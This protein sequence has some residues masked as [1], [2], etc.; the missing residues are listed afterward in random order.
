MSHPYQ[1]RHRVAE[2]YLSGCE[3]VVDVGTYKVPLRL[4][5]SKLV[6]IDPLGVTAGAEVT[7]VATWWVSNRPMSGFGLCMLGFALEGSS[8]Q[9]Q[10]V[11]EM[12]EAAS[13]VVV[14]WAADYV[15]Q[16]G[17][18]ATLTVGKQPVFQG[19]FT[20]PETPTAGFPVFARRHMA[21]C[22]A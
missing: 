5:D 10:A 19:S 2:H 22:V 11:L 20:L 3:T 17:H 16:F 13:V 8:V 18:P 21:V 7:D 9:F 6:C 15:H 1:V 12:A 4:P 14:E